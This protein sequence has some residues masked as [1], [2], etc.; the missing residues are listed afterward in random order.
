MDK[1]AK[2]FCSYSDILFICPNNDL[3]IFVSIILLFCS[4]ISFKS[5]SKF[6]LKSDNN[7]SFSSFNFFSYLSFSNFSSFSS[8]YSS[9]IYLLLFFPNLLSINFSKSSISIILLLLFAFLVVK[10]TLN[11]FIF[12]LYLSKSFWDSIENSSLSEFSIFNINSSFSDKSKID[13]ISLI[14]FL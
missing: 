2:F 5:F 6:F 14:N 7:L 8:S 3:F 4:I 13:I 11:D 9:S 1:F 12:L 10:Y